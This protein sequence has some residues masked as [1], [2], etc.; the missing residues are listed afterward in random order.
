MEFSPRGALLFAN[1]LDLISTPLAH[2]G[3]DSKRRILY[4]LKNDGNS[5]SGQA[6]G[7]KHPEQKVQLL[8]TNR[9]RQVHQF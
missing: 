3:L 2:C 7:N 6:A 1:N 8:S 9:Q 4:D 5:S